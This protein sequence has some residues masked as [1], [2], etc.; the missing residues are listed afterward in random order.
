MAFYESTFIANQE[1]TTKQVD[2]LAQNFIDFLKHSG[3]KLVRKEYWGVKNFTYAIKKQKKGH[4]V[5]LAIEC[6]AENILAYENKMKSREEILKYL[7]IK[8]EKIADKPSALA[9]TADKE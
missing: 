3:G 5:M 8:V 2:D 7:N 9:K 6:P 4:Y 1:L